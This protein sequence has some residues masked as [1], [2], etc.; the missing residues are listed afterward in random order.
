MKINIGEAGSCT[1]EPAHK[2]FMAVAAF[3]SPLFKAL[4]RASKDLDVSMSWIMKTA[5]AGD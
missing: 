5:V 1:L 3:P 4:S 2:D